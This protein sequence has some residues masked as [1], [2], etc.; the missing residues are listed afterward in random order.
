MSWETPHKKYLNLANSTIKFH[1]KKILEVGGCSPIEILDTFNP[2]SWTCIDM[3]ANAVQDFNNTAKLSGA[4]NCTAIEQD[5]TSYKIK[6]EYDLIYSINSFEHI[7]DF[8]IALDKMYQFL[9][10][11]GYLYSLFGPIWSSDVGNHLSV[12]ANNG[13]EV[14]FYD[15][16]LEP[17]EHLTSTPELLQKKLENMYDI[18]TA[19]KAVE[20]IYTYPDLNR[21]CEHEYL[22]LIKKSNFNPVIILKRKL[23]TPPDISG[24]TST[25]ELLVVL[26]KGNVSLFDKISCFIKFGLAFVLNR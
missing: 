5:I 18:D 19:K 10:G 25:R 13:E 23:V 16:V 12:T 9:K 11:D 2:L 15:D 4:Q 14:N 7:H 22:D 24:A 21:L 26:K 8:N 17:W 6:N 20:Y 1:N 3:D